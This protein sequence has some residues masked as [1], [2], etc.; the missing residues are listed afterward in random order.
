MAAE[1]IET[2]VKEIVC[3]QFRCGKN[4]A[5]P[6]TSFIK[7]LGAGSLDI[8]ELVM[9]LEKEFTIEIPDEEIKRIGTVRNLIRCIESK[10]THAR[11]PLPVSR[12]SIRKLSRVSLKVSTKTHC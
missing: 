5:Q 2:R 4:E 11:P 7:D 8:I 12:N 10:K 6:D 1:N 3:E 9:N